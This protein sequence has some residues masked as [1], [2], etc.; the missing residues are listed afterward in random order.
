M[1]FSTDDN[2]FG[3]IKTIDLKPDGRNVEVTDDNKEEY[4]KSVI[5][6]RLGR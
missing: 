6:S 1:T 5:R 4:V 3:E 2:I